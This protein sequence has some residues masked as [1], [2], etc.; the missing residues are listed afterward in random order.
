MVDHDSLLRKPPSGLPLWLVLN[1]EG[2]AVGPI[3]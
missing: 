2:H 1:L 3:R